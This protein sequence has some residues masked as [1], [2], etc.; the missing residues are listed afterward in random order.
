PGSKERTRLLPDSMGCADIAARRTTLRANRQGRPLVGGASTIIESN[1]R[2]ESDY[3]A[4]SL[5]PQLSL[6]APTDSTRRYNLGLQELELRVLLRNFAIDVGREY[7]VWGQGR[8]V[9]LLNSNNS[10]PLDLI[11]LSS[12][13]PFTFPWLLRYVGPTRFSIFYA[14]LGAD[15][16]FPHSYLVG[17]KGSIL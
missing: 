11:K 7:L 17:Y 16:N 9:G 13:E 8:D 14:E 10:P 3:A 2:V 5:T 4:L 15:Q 1:H 6:V 12:D